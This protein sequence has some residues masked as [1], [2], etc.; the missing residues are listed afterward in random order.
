MARVLTPDPDPSPGSG[1]SPRRSTAPHS[2]ASSLH[3]PPEPPPTTRIW[4]PRSTLDP[5]SRRTGGSQSQISP[6]L[7]A[8]GSPRSATG[9]WIL[10]RPQ[11][12]D[13]I[14]AMSRSGNVPSPWPLDPRVPLTSTTGSPDSL[15]L[16]LLPE[17][18][19]ASPDPDISI[20]L[21]SARSQVP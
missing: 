12:P 9:F 11:S 15:I 20:I 21:Q 19:A 1:G 14:N 17:P 13:P 2:Q 10:K 3:R 5:R 4:C 18:S 16:S 7:P 8:T 6:T